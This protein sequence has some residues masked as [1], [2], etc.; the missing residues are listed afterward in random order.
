MSAGTVT[1]GVAV[2]Q[3]VGPAP[4]KPRPAWTFAE[5]FIIGQTALPALLYLP[6]VQALRLP[7]R[8]AP[9]AVSLLALAWW[10]A[11]RRD[12]SVRHPS[13][14]W[15][16][17]GLAWMALM[18]LHPT[19]AGVRAGLAQV[20]LYV[21]VLAPL[22]WA[23]RFVDSYRQFARILWILLICNGIN[24]T[25]GVLQVYDP[26]RWMPYSLSRLVTESD[27]G[28]GPVSYVGPDGRRIIRP[29]GLFDTPGSVAGAGMYAALLGVVFAASAA[30]LWRRALAAAFA[31]SGIAAIYLSQVRVSLV[32]LA[33]MLA[34]YLGCL[35][36][37]R[38]TATLVRSGLLTAFVIVAG[39]TFSLALGGE[40][41]RERVLTLFEDDPVTLYQQT[42]G[43]QLT[44]TFRQLLGEFPLGAGLGRWGMAGAYF[45]ETSGASPSPIWAEIQI[46]GWVL[47][48]GLLLLAFYGLALVLA[49]LTDYR[50]AIGPSDSYMN[51]SAAVVL[52]ANLGTA[53]LIFSFT[54]FV[55][56]VGQQYWFLA[57][58]LHGLAVRYGHIR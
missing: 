11:S 12:R 26:D 34:T 33:L 22:L 10:L 25:V 24:S 35:V 20:A 39:F 40:S 37:Q 41:V 9:F 21:A 43:E 51:A 30:S 31:F 32:V 16:L 53:A 7:I 28:L 46:T 38:R 1:A 3:A 44:Y 17:I 57:G 29:P 5:I 19:T 52:A 18:M 15:V 49:S 45:G 50:L 2:S 54:P 6:N 23:S 4:V 48:G 56:Q 42:R 27:M 14:A 36:L 55:T 8:I 47:D 58:A 13:S